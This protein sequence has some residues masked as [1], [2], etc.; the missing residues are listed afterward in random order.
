MTRVLGI[1]VSSTT[2]GYCILDIDQSNKISFIH[3]NYL[4][5]LKEGTIIERIVDTR[6][7]LKDIMDGYQPDHIGVEDIIKFMKGK[8]SADTVV[9]LTTFNRMTC[10]LAHDHL[11]K[12]P[13][14]FNVLSIRHG[15]KQNNIFP[16]KEDMPEL[17]A[18]HLGITFP[19]QFG[20]KG[21][22]QE[23]SYDMADGVAVALYYAFVL[24]GQVKRK[25]K[26]VGTVKKK[27]KVKKK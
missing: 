27:R 26:K 13:E 14:L 10:L 19:Y 20:K 18:K 8:S 12:S 4:K 3:A 17:V 9:M 22:V 2:I 1:D 15:L 24:T 16:K 23:E 11:Q 25:I 6:N 21:K 5:P 7:R